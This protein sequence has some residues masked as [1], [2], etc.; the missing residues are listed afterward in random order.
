MR[1]SEQD[2]SPA[3][4]LAFQAWLD[5]DADNV[6]V[7]AEIIGAWQAVDRYAATG[8]M[9]ELREDALISARK[10]R[11]Q[12]QDTQ[13]AS[14][15]PAWMLVAAC[16]CLVAVGLSIWHT[17]QPTI[18]ATGLGERRIVM[19]ED[20]SRLSLD[21]GTRVRVKY[22]TDG[23]KFWLERGRAKFS[24]A[25]NPLRPFSVAAGGKLVVAT[26]TEFSVELVGPQ[27]RVILYEGHVAVIDSRPVSAVPIATDEK[28]RDPNR[29]YLALDP[30]DELIVTKSDAGR[31][32]PKVQ[33]LKP[34]SQ[35]ISAEW[36]TGLL[37]FN[38]ETLAVVAE[39]TNRY[40]EKPLKLA[41][42]GVG[43][44]RISGVFRAGDTVS[45]VEGLSSTLG[46]KAR[47]QGRQI[48]LTAPKESRPR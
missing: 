16:L 45:L 31:A 30:G 14:R 41:D 28:S 9:M 12:V 36:E 29:G 15:G 43:Q 47:A 34:A 17:Q 21:A 7:M 24:V 38:N 22:T 25:K 27:T 42:D 37:V 33:L 6:D 44:L 2:M 4:E 39:R 20:D 40:A 23:R 48:M 19:L 13:V 32:I 1:L 8:P 11:E 18:Y 46:V 3:D 35:G 26:G 10:M 5:G